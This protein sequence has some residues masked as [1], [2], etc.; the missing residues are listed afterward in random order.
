MSDPI[1]DLFNHSIGIQAPWRVTSVEFSKENKR[2]DITVD[3]QDGTKN[4]S[5]L[6][7]KTWALFLR[8]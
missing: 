3:Y 4:G 6:G 8:I 2:L 7:K 1:L 5:P